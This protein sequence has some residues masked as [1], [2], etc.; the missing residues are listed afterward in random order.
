MRDKEKSPSSSNSEEGDRV[1]P[2]DTSAASPRTTVASPVTI[3]G[4]SSGWSLPLTAFPGNPSGM[5]AAVRQNVTAAGPLPIHTG[6][7]IE[8]EDT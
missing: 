1:F 6:F 5:M 2:F 4:R 7:P 8:S 3:S